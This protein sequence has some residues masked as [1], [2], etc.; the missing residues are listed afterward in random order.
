MDDSL[1]MIFHFVDTLLAGTI[2]TTVKRLVRL[3]PMT[4]DSAAAVM[5]DRS[6]LVNRALEAIKSMF[7]SGG[8]YLERQ[9]IFIPTHFA[10]RHSFLSLCAVNDLRA[11]GQILLAIVT[12]ALCHD[13]EADRSDGHLQ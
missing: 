10:L 1:D 4:D 11:V 7:C 8:D 2:G 5:A 12:I 13:G 3:N 9:I 6:Q